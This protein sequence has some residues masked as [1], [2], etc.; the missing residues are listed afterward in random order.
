M[1]ITISGKYI[2]DEPLYLKHRM[3]CT[4]HTNLNHGNPSSITKLLPLQ[5]LDK[6]NSLNFECLKYVIPAVVN[7]LKILY[8][9]TLTTKYLSKRSYD[10]TQDSI[11]ALY[12][13]IKNATFH[14][15]RVSIDLSWLHEI[16]KTILIN[17]TKTMNSL[18]LLCDGCSC[19]NIL[20]FNDNNLKD[21]FHLCERYDLACE[22]I[23]N[24]KYQECY[25]VVTSIYDEIIC[26]KSKLR[27]T[28]D[29]FI[30]MI[31][32]MSDVKSFVSLLCYDILMILIC[33]TIYN[34]QDGW[35]C[36]RRIQLIDKRN[37]MM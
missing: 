35:L 8:L 17:I 6:Y 22:V 28:S 21:M 31:L 18:K 12:D 32:G 24:I 11:I 16:N 33:H 20:E 15:V 1:I 5:L 19:I 9:I 25:N 36:L 34:V 27:N 29:K 30:V 37:N 4:T 14:R 7:K 23:S 10:V 3:M 13:S 26:L 2:V